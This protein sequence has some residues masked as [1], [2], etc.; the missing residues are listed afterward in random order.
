MGRAPRT[1]AMRPMAPGARIP[2]APFSTLHHMRGGRRC[3]ARAAGGDEVLRSLSANRE[4]SVLTSVGT[5][6]V[7]EA[8]GRHVTAPTASAA[9][10][11]V[12][13]GTLL[14]GCFR[15]D[16][17]VTQISFTGD[18]P[19]GVVQAIA[20]DSGLVRGRIGCPSANLPLRGDG[21]LDVGGLIGQGVVTVVR[22]GPLRPQP[23]SGIVPIA[24][25]EV[26]EDLATYLAKS[27]QVNTA[28]ALGV[29]VNR[30]G[31][32]RSAG[33]FVV[34]VL[35]NASDET[36]DTLEGTLARI[37]TVTDMIHDGLGPADM[38]EALFGGIGVA[39]GAVALT[40][41]YGPCNP[42]RILRD[43]PQVLA[44]MG[45]EEV[46]KVL[47]E[48]GCIEAR[49]EFCNECVQ[50]GPEEVLSQLEK[51]SQGGQEES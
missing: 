25:G 21:K 27:E 19:S 9:L 32:I 48:Q 40:P 51:I 34:Q 4:L 12:I 42:D 49:D 41:R 26:A 31:S 39:P 50:V 24:T 16:G 47:D 14:L 36:L 37:P 23:Y 22:S 8:T 2:P 46:R 20:N 5:A 45:E 30:D 10:G 44:A 29:A 18:G 33:G 35:P 7:S 28:L 1:D 11:R 13:M 17:E 15:K 38:A 6:V 43:L 3:V